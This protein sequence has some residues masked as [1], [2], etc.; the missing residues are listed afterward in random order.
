MIRWGAISLMWKQE[1]RSLLS[2]SRRSDAL[3]SFP[4]SQKFRALISGTTALPYP[5][6][7]CSW[8]FPKAFRESYTFGVDGVRIRSQDEMIKDW[9]LRFIISA[10]TFAAIMMG[11]GGSTTLVGVAYVPLSR[12]LLSRYNP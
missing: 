12:S 3:S 8:R 5:K 10:T 1:W 11:W 7:P 9:L 2:C 4:E 6:D